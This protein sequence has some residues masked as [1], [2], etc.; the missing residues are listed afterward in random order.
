MDS[1]NEKTNNE[2]D[3]LPIEE[4]IRLSK[5]LLDNVLK[6]ND[7]VKG[8]AEVEPYCDR[9]IYHSFLKMI[10]MIITAIVTMD[11]LDI[12]S[13]NQSVEETKKLCNKY[14]KTGFI[15]SFMK[16]L[17]TP[18]Y[19]KYTDL[20]LHSELIHTICY[21]SSAA[22]LA[23]ETNNIY[24]LIRLAYRLQK[25]IKNFRYCKISAKTR[26]HWENEL[27][28]NTYKSAVLL[29]N[30]LRNLAISNIPPKVLAIINFLGIKGS[31]SNGWKS[32][33]EGT[34]VEPGIFS[35]PCV[36]F[37][38]AYWLY[39]E[40]HG[41]MG[42][43]NNDFCRQVL[44]SQLEIYPKNLILRTAEA[45]LEEISGNI[46]KA[47]EIYNELLSD[48]HMAPKRIFHFHLMFCYALKCDWDPCI[49]NA[50]KFRT[51]SLY[52]PAMATYF[53]AIVRYAKAVDLD[54]KEEMEKAVKLFKV[55]PSL[56]IRHLGKTITPEK[57]AVVRSENFFKNNNLLVLP[58]IEVLCET[59]YIIF[60]KND[61]NLLQKFMSRID[62]QINKHKEDLSILF[63]Y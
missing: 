29:G 31:E 11:K 51:G 27:S 24:S 52:S 15:I 59:N 49:D 42:P 62:K 45:K 33:N 26:T 8:L 39:A 43:K 6:D 14:R 57:I 46:D 55:T 40:P 20:E 54:D 38:I 2:C 18:D 56:R 44:N 61:K 4:S 47:I 37:R 63:F 30:G 60:I 34:L 9:S 25:C 41:Y 19:D 12:E 35:I 7:T 48:P 28:E 17:K 3:H 10:C 22:V 5:Q 23:I 58:D 53:E 21:V 13:A 16:L 50:S 36:W 32:I 1:Q